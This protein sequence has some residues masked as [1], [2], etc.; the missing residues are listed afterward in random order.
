MWRSPLLTTAPVILVKPTNALLSV[1]VI[2]AAL[3]PELFT[4]DSVSSLSGGEMLPVGNAMLFQNSPAT[5]S[6]PAISPGSTVLLPGLTADESQKLILIESCA[7]D[8]LPVQANAA[9]SGTIIP[10]ARKHF[11]IAVMM[12][13]RE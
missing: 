9:A 11:W 1:D 10:I 6:M 3:T 2:V 8:W 12:L 7:A 4:T 13:S 5:G